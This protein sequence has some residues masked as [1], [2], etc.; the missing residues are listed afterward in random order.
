MGW[1]AEPTCSDELLMLVWMLS[2]FRMTSM[3]RYVVYIGWSMAAR[4]LLEQP[5][6]LGSD[7]D[8]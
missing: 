6:S 8:H 1:S 5:S 3:L 2:R 4:P 7:A